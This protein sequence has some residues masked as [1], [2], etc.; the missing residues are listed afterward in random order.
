MSLKAV[1]VVAALLLS[2]LV[3]PTAAQ[4]GIEFG[5][6]RERND[7]DFVTIVIR[8]DGDSRIELF[9]G[10]I[11]DLRSDARQARLEPQTRFLRPGERHAWD[12]IH[13]GNAGRF[14]ARF[15]TSAG[16]FSDRFEVG[17]F[18]HLGFR[19]DD[20][21]EM[22]CAPIDPFVIWA[23]E[24]RPIRELRADLARPEDERRIVS[25]I[26]RRQKRYNPYWSFTMGPASIVLGEVFIEVCDAHPQYVEE[27]RREWMGERW[28]PWS[29]F[30]KSEGR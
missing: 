24:D 12:W 5:A 29:S 1:A 20:T 10:S 25:G 23:H 17:A 3:S 28:C 16:R 26:V 30:V 2:A 22:D 27:N 14:E 8:N 6:T 4:T 7:R 21:P 15:Q 19:C 11:W 13:E 18:F 9:G